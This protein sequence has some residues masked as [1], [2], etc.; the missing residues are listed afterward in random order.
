MNHARVVVRT[1]QHI[2]AIATASSERVEELHRQRDECTFRGH[3]RVVGEYPA[4]TPQHVSGSGPPRWRSCMLTTLVCLL[5]PPPDPP[6]AR[7]HSQNS[8]LR[9]NSDRASNTPT[10][11]SGTRWKSGCE[12]MERARA[13]APASVRASHL[14]N[15]SLPT[16]GECASTDESAPIVTTTTPQ[17]ATLLRRW[18]VLTTTL[19]PAHTVPRRGAVA[20]GK[21]RAGDRAC[22]ASATLLAAAHW[23]SQRRT[24]KRRGYGGE[25]G[26]K[27]MPT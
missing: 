14:P 7:T 4:S 22:T 23:Q 3:R 2:D 16:N 1:F 6:A 18:R 19:A 13:A 5:D 12:A 27:T 10:S 9:N 24:H 8:F 15:S 20:G 17:G 11:R 21:R 26:C 25:E